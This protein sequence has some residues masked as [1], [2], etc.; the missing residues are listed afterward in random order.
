MD[1]DLKRRSVCFHCGQPLE[2]VRYK[3]NPSKP[4]KCIEC[5]TIDQKLRKRMHRL[6]KQ[7][8]KQI[9]NT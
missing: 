4:P 3:F 1:I 5:K 6:E 8:L 2:K 9:K 7:S